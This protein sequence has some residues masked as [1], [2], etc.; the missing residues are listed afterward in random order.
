[1]L[2]ENIYPFEMLSASYAKT[3][4][5]EEATD[6]LSRRLAMI[7]ENTYGATREQFL[8]IVINSLE[9]DAS[10]ALSDVFERLGE[11]WAAAECLVGREHMQG[12]I[13][14]RI[15]Y[16]RY[17]DALSLIEKAE[18]IGAKHPVE[19]SAKIAELRRRLESETGQTPER[20]GWL[21]RFFGGI[22]R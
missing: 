18:A 17:D 11:Y 7:G 8:G 6:T 19:Q 15:A 10:V 12:P 9:R 5:L 22:T 20:R 14:V 16:K 13:G 21:R 4:R 2:V 3:G 1:M